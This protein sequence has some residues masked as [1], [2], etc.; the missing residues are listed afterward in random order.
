MWTIFKIYDALSHLR[1][2]KKQII[3]LPELDNEIQLKAA[4]SFNRVTTYLSET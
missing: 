3:L 2:R 4:G 1:F